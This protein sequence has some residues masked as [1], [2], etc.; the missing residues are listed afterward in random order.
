VKFSVYVPD[1]LWEAASKRLGGKDKNP[2]QVVQEALRRRLS[3]EEARASLLAE[4][5]SVDPERFEAVRSQLLRGARSEFERGYTAGLELA[6]AL[7][8]DRL[9]DMACYYEYE[10]EDLAGNWGVEG[11]PWEK[12][13][14]KHDV[15]VDA[16]FPDERFALFRQGVARALQDLWAAL[17]ESRWSAASEQADPTRSKQE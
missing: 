16:D 14:E 11:E 6:E 12:W 17:G 3:E 13:F 4:G 5:V 15:E 7:D 10:L 2:S 8:F 1:E 9:A